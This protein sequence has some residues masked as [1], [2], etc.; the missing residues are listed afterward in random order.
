MSL[1]L[2][3]SD[4]NSEAVMPCYLQ[5]F[6][7]ANLTNTIVISV[8]R[9]HETIFDIVVSYRDANSNDHLNCCC[10][11]QYQLLL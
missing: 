3:I 5:M 4:M 2:L 7:L 11:C 8:S 6:S 1:K 9:R 10:C